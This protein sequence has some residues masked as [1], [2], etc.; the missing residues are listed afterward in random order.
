MAITFDAGSTGQVASALTLTISHTVG[1]G[2]DRVLV[3]LVHSIAADKLSGAT[4]TYNGVSLGAPVLAFAAG[5]TYGWVMVAPPVGTAN[6]V[7]TFN[8]ADAYANAVVASF[9]G[10]DQSTP[11]S[12]TGTFNDGFAGSPRSLSVTTPTD[13]ACLDILYIANAS[14]TMTPTGSGQTM[15]GSKMVNSG[16]WS[17]AGSYRLGAASSMD[18]TFTGGVLAAQ[19]G[20]IALAP[21]AGGPAEITGSSSITLGAVT[22]VAEGTVSSGI[23]G[24]S[25][26]TLGAVTS[27][28]EGTV[29][30]LGAITG[31]SSITLGAVTSAAAGAVGATLTIGPVENKSGTVLAG[32]SIGHLVALARTTRAVAISQAGLTTDGSGMLAVRDSSLVPGTDY[33]V[34]TWTTDG[35][36]AGNAKVTAVA[37][38]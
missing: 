6:V 2:S 19:Q 14:T 31:A 10:V 24:S 25:S 35:A 8:A 29:T 27:V 36:N 23:T 37:V 7:I 26:I 32:A 18:W 33:M 1:A 38:P 28:A 9:A 15:V 22:S 3:V 11:V 30:G 20:A 12:A 5:Y 13:G 21:A 4:V 34:A 17:T 16:V